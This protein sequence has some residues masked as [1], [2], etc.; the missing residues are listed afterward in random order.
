VKTITVKID[1]FMYAKL[2]AIAKR[3]G[4]TQSTVVR[5]AIMTCL[6]EPKVRRIGSA[7]DLAKDLAGCV[8]GPAD[9]STSKTHL[10]RFGR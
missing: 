10:Q 9:L 1:E 6:E 4:A 2:S 8:T 5:E 3:R 7:L